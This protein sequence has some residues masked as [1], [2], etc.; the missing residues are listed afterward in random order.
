MHTFKRSTAEIQ[1]S[2]MVTSL[3]R[4]NDGQDFLSPVAPVTTVSMGVC[5]SPLSVLSH[6][7]KLAIGFSTGDGVV[8]VR[9]SNEAILCP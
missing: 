2:Q 7:Y 3:L 5:V 6:I 9:N 1:Q 8:K 4:C